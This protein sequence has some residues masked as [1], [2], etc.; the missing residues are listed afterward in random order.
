MHNLSLD[1]YFI[2][3][4]PATSHAIV[5]KATVRPVKNKIESKV[6]ISNELNRSHSLP[7]VNLLIH[8]EKQNKN[9]D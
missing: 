1:L 7:Q 2:D 4:A 8:V 5:A 3:S 6:K 9:K